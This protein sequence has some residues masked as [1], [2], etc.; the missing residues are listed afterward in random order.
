MT[1]VSYNKN[2]CILGT[3]RS[4]TKIICELVKLILGSHFREKEISTIY[5][6]FLWGEKIWNG[7]AKG[8]RVWTELS[9]LSIDGIY[10]NKKLPLFLDR[11]NG[12]ENIGYFK[13][14]FH[15][16]KD[17][18]LVV[19]TIRGLGRL[20]FFKFYLQDCK[21]IFTI[22]NPV[23]VI[24]SVLPLFSFYGDDYYASDFPRFLSEVKAVFDESLDVNK[25]DRHI[26]K[27]VQYWFY[28]N[29]YFLENILENQENVLII[30]YENFIEDKRSTIIK[31]CD[32]LQLPYHE[33]YYHFSLK[34]IGFVTNKTNLTK[35]EIIYLQPFMQVYKSLL[36]QHGIN[37]NGQVL[38]KIYTKL[39]KRPSEYSV[40]EKENYNNRI[41]NFLRK[42][43]M[44]R[45]E[46][47]SE[48]HKIIS[49]KSCVA[50]E[51]SQ[52]L[53]ES[54]KHNAVL[55][56]LISRMKVCD[57]DLLKKMH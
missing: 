40:C 36:Q 16:E 51:L 35:D 19:K 27:E 45:D 21:F 5:E 14:I 30:S 6:P 7:Y 4:G 2:I 50:E 31:I 1:K 28:M 43:L 18:H 37:L 8:G 48:L 41:S 13:S 17:N 12:F 44:N 9:S 29:R 55:R 47:I 32:F 39:I 24:N 23:S 11:I 49:E 57:M 10:W 26:K 56:Q 46:H 42:Q 15:Q 3:G 52:K 25:I 33:S 54:E 53:L 34:N 22:R 20:K 38:E